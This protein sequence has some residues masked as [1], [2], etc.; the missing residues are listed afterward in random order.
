MYRSQQQDV[1]WRPV[2]SPSLNHPPMVLPDANMGSAAEYVPQQQEH[3]FQETSVPSHQQ[4]YR[5]ETTSPTRPAQPKSKLGL[6]SRKRALQRSQTAEKIGTSS[7]ASTPPTLPQD[8]DGTTLASSPTVNDLDEYTDDIDAGAGADS[9]ILTL[10]ESYDDSPLRHRG[11]RDNGDSDV[12]QSPAALSRR[13]ELILA[14]AKERFLVS[15][16]RYFQGR[17]GKADALQ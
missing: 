10:D 14:K 11:A 15:R 5:Y 7:D 9:D 2:P 4:D 17:R 3:N 16:V 6:M 13:A 1:R 8:D 12:D